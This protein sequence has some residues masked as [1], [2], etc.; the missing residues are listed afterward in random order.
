MPNTGITRG[1]STWYMQD[2]YVE[3]IMDNAAYTSAH[4]DDTLVLAGPPR[5]PTSKTGNESTTNNTAIVNKMLAIGHLQSVQFTQQKPTQPVMAIGSGRTFFVSGKAQGQCT[6]GRLFVNGRNLLRVLY[7]NA[8]SADLAVEKMDDRAA[9]RKAAQY[10]V[11]LDSEL[12]LIPF[13]IGSIFRDKIHDMIGGFYAELSMITSYALG[14]NAGQNMI[15]EQVNIV[16]DRL[17][18][19]FEDNV[20]TYNINKTT[21][22]TVMG[23]SSGTIGGTLEDAEAK[24]GNIGK[25]TSS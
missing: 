4:P 5:T 16:F 24:D 11:N 20:L 3:R 22:D 17:A 25:K 19:F 18:P 12:Y 9:N 10:Y 8:R 15:M 2:N 1:V 23:F 13:G 6:M 21:L 14:F 7:H